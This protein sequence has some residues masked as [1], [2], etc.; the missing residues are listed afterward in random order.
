[1]QKAPVLQLHF[2]SRGQF[3]F[4][5]ILHYVHQDLSSVDAH[6]CPSF[7]FQTWHETF[8]TGLAPVGGATGMN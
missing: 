2:A 1:M 6:C 7:M 4:K 5:Q 8:P 3:S